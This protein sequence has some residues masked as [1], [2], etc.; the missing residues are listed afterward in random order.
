MTMLEQSQVVALGRHTG[1]APAVAGKQGFLEALSRPLCKFMVAHCG[2][3]AN[4]FLR[5]SLPYLRK[6][7]RD[8]DTY[9]P[10]KLSGNQEKRFTAKEAKI[11]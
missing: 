3:L 10:C 2:A 6:P 8:R 5:I 7:R 4:P 11:S 9:R 1:R